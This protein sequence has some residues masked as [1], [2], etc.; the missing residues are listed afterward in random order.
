MAASSGGHRR[1][2]LGGWR[3]ALSDGADTRVPALRPRAAWPRA[4]NPARRRI[5]PVAAGRRP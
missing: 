2:D 1:V 3:D 4:A 5:D